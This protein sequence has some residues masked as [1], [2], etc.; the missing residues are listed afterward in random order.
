MPLMSFIYPEHV[1]NSILPIYAFL[2]PA[3]KV[4]ENVTSIEM[5]VRTVKNI[6]PCSSN[7]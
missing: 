7:A 1:S 5:P 3:I 6:N 2:S 4:E